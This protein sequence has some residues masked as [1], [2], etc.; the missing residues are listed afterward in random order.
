[1]AERIERGAGLAVESA[2]KLKELLPQELCS[3]LGP[4]LEVE[5]TGLSH[6]SR[7]A[8]AGDIYFALARDE[9]QRRRNA[10]QALERGV[11]AVV[12]EGWKG[13]GTRPAA[14]IINCSSPR[15]LM[16]LVAARFYGEPSRALELLGVTG[17]SGKTTTSFLLAAMAEAAGR[18]A[19]II[20]TIGAFAARRKLFSGLTTPES[21]DLQAALRAMKELGC[22]FVCAEISSIG[23]D[24]GRAE[25]LDFRACLF[26]NLG[27][28]HLD[29][30]GTLDNYFAAKLRLFTEI[31]AR[32]RQ[33]DPV[34]VARGDD[35]YGARV[36]AL[37]PGRK[38]SF[39]LR[40]D[41]DVYPLESSLSFD[42]IRTRLSV[43]GEELAVASPL[44]GEINL[45]NLLGAV[46]V[47]RALGFPAEAVA[48]GAASCA[49]PPGRLEGV[50]A[51]DGIGVFVDYAHKPD[52]LAGVLNA[53][54]GLAAGRL[55]CVFG[56]GGDRDRG[57]R[58]LMGEVAGRLADLAV[59]TSDN[60]RSEDPGAIIDQ[61]ETGLTRAGLPRLT[62]LPHAGARGYL[63]EPE[64]RRAIEA[65]IAAARPGDVVLIA[66]KGHEDYQLVA[67]R[68]LSF[69]DRVVA[70]EVLA[71]RGGRRPGTGAV[72]QGASGAGP[73]P[74]PK[75]RLD[76]AGRS[77]APAGG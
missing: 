71:A 24:Q 13:A 61:I 41:L 42:G 32:S 70:R 40:P 1:M 54:R 23:L 34:T 35:P 46:A 52:A 18:P 55:I 53:L 43:F 69:D 44:L 29:Y 60:P 63:I 36:L 4:E 28:D 5:I 22:R 10:Q 27:R 67:G 30:H 59:V 48:K 49:S 64:R 38:V 21:A 26:T 68:R 7:Q 76:C 14:A 47:A 9:A 20:G 16:A 2:V 74:A 11:R 37:A 31:L 6:D 62:G 50:A 66:G 58:P 33:D 75:R 17:T 25:G 73:G 51:P 12:M 8:G 57:K 39:G 56:C 77:E 65:A 72:S 45:L 15:R 3:S 19:G